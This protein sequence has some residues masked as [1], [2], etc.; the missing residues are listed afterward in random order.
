MAR[1]E[2]LRKSSEPIIHGPSELRSLKW[3]LA[4]LSVRAVSNLGVNPVKFHT[5]DSDKGVIK[6]S[7][8]QEEGQVRLQIYDCSGEAADEIVKIDLPVNA[9]IIDEKF[10]CGYDRVTAHQLN[11]IADL[12]SPY[13]L[14]IGYGVKTMPAEMYI[15]FFEDPK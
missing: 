15:K 5:F 1:I 11:A 7:I 14:S 10:A 2:N 4:S 13:A 8:G 12:F 9:T 6:L 3:A